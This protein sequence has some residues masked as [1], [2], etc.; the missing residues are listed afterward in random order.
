LDFWVEAVESFGAAPVVVLPMRNPLEVASSLL[1]RDRMDLSVGQLLWLRYVLDAEYASRRLRRVFLLYEDLLSDWQS[2]AD[3]LSEKLGIAWP[4]RLSATQKIE[5]L[6]S[7]AKRHH[8]ADDP[9]IFGAKSVSPW[10]QSTFEILARWARGEIRESDMHDLDRIKSA[11]DEAASSFYR[12][13]LAANQS[14]IEARDLRIK[15]IARER[16]LQQLERSTSWR[17]TAPFREVS[18]AVRSVLH[19]RGRKAR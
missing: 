17:I 3:K 18:R 11:F 5:A 15:L 2:V 14:R 16:A 10:V 7:P 9:S 12:P 6:V 19:K 8:R 4:N 1:V 13:V